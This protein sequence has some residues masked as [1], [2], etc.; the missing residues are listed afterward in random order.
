MKNLDRRVAEGVAHA[1]DASFTWCTA[2]APTATRAAQSAAQFTAANSHRAKDIWRTAFLGKD[3]YPPRV[4]M[5]AARD[6]GGTLL[7]RLRS[8]L[9]FFAFVD[10]A[11]SSGGELACESAIIGRFPMALA[12]GLKVLQSQG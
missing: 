6:G 9:S 10:S 8:P 2:A 1:P 3:V 12:R 11:A 4:G 5:R 7:P